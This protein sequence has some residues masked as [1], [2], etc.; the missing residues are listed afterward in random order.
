M[1]DENDELETWDLR[2]VDF[3]PEEFW[4]M[5]IEELIPKAEK[6][7][8]YSSRLKKKG[9][10]EPKSKKAFSGYNWTTIK[11][12]NRGQRDKIKSLKAKGKLTDQEKVTLN[13]VTQLHK[14]SSWALKMHKEGWSDKRIHAEAQKRKAK[15][16]T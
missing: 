9:T 12:M 5:S 3:L 6:D 10:K 14:W 8:F 13:R 11:K 1:S 15:A 4:A 7:P 2:E 16:S